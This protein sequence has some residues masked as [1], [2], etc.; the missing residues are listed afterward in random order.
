MIKEMH[1][2]IHK[3][4]ERDDIPL[5]ESDLL[6]PKSRPGIKIYIKP[7]TSRIN[8]DVRLT[9]YDI[10]LLYYAK[11][12]NK[13]Y[14][15]HYEMME[16]ITDKLIGCLELDNGVWI[17]IDDIDFEQ[18]DDMLAAYF[19]AEVDTRIDSEADNEIMEELKLKRS[20]KE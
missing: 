7:R 3:A 13:Y 1:R 6:E 5:M 11:D 10:M 9:T 16:E 14:I 8:S 2:G 19:S 15:E 4:L 17:D 18:D 20:D 12:I